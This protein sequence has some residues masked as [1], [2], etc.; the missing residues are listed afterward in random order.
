MASEHLGLHMLAGE[1]ALCEAVHAAKP[2]QDGLGT[3]AYHKDQDFIW[4]S[5]GL[6]GDDSIITELCIGMDPIAC[7]EQQDRSALQQLR[8]EDKNQVQHHWWLPKP[9]RNDC[10][11]HFV[12]ECIANGSNPMELLIP[13]VMAGSSSSKEEEI[14]IWM[15]YIT[16]KTNKIN[17]ALLPK[18]VHHL[19][20]GVFEKVKAKKRKAV[21]DGEE[22]I[23]K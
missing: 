17:I 21:V 2:K 20:H 5:S 3:D 15:S 16:K 8:W 23:T 19:H 14:K 6:E 22:R 11:A 7:S 4:I 9:N 12:N 18:Q 1:H 13:S 10:L